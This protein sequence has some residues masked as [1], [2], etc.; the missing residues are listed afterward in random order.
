MALE[1]EM[2]LAKALLDR[3]ELDEAEAL[4]EKLERVA[5]AQQA[6][7]EADD[8]EDTDGDDGDEEDEEDDGDDDDDVTKALDEVITVEGVRVA[9]SEVGSGSFAIL[10]GQAERLDD[11]E[12]AFR[13]NH[14]TYP[15]DDLTDAMNE[16][17]QVE[18]PQLNTH[19][20]WNRF[21]ERTRAIAARDA[22][23]IH[24][25]MQRARGEMGAEQIAELRQP[26]SAVRKL[27]LPKL[28]PI[29][30]QSEAETLEEGGK[31]KKQTHMGR[32]H[33]K[34]DQQVK[35][36]EDEV[37]KEMAKGLSR[38]LAEQRVMHTYGNT[39]P[40]SNILKGAGDSLVVRFMEK[41]DE[42]M[43]DE[44]V[45]RTTAMSIV[46]KRHEGL[47]DAFQVV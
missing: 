24:V 28:E 31:R 29:Y 15:R 47:F 20:T 2:A 46:R 5:K 18:H 36:H 45:D 38:E 41:V 35:T 39:L 16:H 17:R 23:P 26:I 13:E 12:K 44:D 32:R 3:G 4:M 37:A 27:G 14:I 30:P 34:H 22:C 8:D 43:I 7:D 1:Q 40:R 19:R 11:L 42:C 10:K 6:A 9:K 33:K 21:M 25:A